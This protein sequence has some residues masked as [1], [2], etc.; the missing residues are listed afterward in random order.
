[1]FDKRL[2]KRIPPRYQTSSSSLWRSSSSSFNSRSR[3]LLGGVIFRAR[4]FAAVDPL[5]DAKEIT[6]MLEPTYGAYQGTGFGNKHLH[7][8]ATR[9]LTNMLVCMIAERQRM[10]VRRVFG[11]AKMKS[12]GRSHGRARRKGSNTGIPSASIASH[13]KVNFASP[14]PSLHQRVSKSQSGSPI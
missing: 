2:N 7:P 4:T 5:A 6:R 12:E 1:M 13:A 11:A 9:F 8:N 10:A 14:A 3:C